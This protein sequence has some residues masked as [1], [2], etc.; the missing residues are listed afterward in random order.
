[1]RLIK[2]QA[3]LLLLDMWMLPLYLEVTRGAAV[4]FQH[5]QSSQV[6]CGTFKFV[7]RDFRISTSV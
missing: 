5:Q 6:R 1:M 3:E 7:L 4:A 2:H